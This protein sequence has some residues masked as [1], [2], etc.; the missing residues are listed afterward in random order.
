[1]YGDCKGI[2]LGMLQ[3]STLRALQNSIRRLQ[4]SGLL[5]RSLDSK[6][7]VPKNKGHVFGD[8][9]VRHGRLLV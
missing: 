2:V 5:D 6:V 4:I 9:C 7:G 3:A 8:A 1:M